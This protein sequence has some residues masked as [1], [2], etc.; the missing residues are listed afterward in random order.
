MDKKLRIGIIGCGGIA[1]GKHMP[2]LKKLDDKLEMVAF[3]DI[4]LE[5]A[6]RLQRSS[7]QRTQRFTR[8]IRS[9]LRTK[10]LMLFTF[11]LPTVH[12]HSLL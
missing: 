9:F 1:N 4:V 5:R 3:C 11:V 7:V 10:P 6:K 8:T 2:N 12:T